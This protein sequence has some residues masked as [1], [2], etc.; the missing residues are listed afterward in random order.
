MATEKQGK[1]SKTRGFLR[2]LPA[3]VAL[4]IV[5]LLASFVWGKLSE[6]VWAYFTDEEGMR[7]DVQEDKD[8]SVLWENPRPNV[9]TAPEDKENTAPD[10]SL[11]KAGNKLEAAFSPN[12]TMMVLVR[13]GAGETGDDLFLSSW[14]GRLWSPPQPLTSLNSAQNERGAAF[15]RDGNFLYFSSDRE[16]GHG[17]YDIYVA[18]RDATGW[19]NVK[20]LEDTVNSASNELGPAPSADGKKLFFSSDRNGDSEDIFAAAI[21]AQPAVPEK[22]PAPDTEP[23]AKA[24]GE[25]AETAPQAPALPSFSMAEA[26]Q[27]LNSEDDDV[28]AALTSRGDHVF[29]ASD[30]DSNEKSGFSVYISRIVK[31]KELPPEKVDLYITEGNTTDPAV[32]MDG[33]DLLFSA[34]SSK[35]STD[36][37]TAGESSGNYRLYRSTTR[38]VFGYTDYT[39]WNK[40]KALLGNIIWWILLAIAALIALIYLLERWRDITDLYH[41]CLAGS[42]VIHLLA[43]LLLAYWMISKEL[44]EGGELQ[45]PEIA[46]SIDALVEEELAL[47]STPEEA[48]ISE[49]PVALVTDKL[50]SDFKIPRFEPQVK[51][52]TTP[53]V[54]RTSKVSLVTDVRPSKANTETSDQP[55]TQPTK[56]T[57]LLSKLPDTVLPELEVPELDERDPGETQ[58]ATEPANPQADIFRPT[59]AIPQ[60]ETEKT[61]E[62]AEVANTAVVNAAETNE[63]NPTDAAAE[64]RDTG[65]ETIVAHT[66]LEALGQPPTLEGSGSVASMNLNLPGTDPKSDPLLPGKLE[67]PKKTVNP[68]AFTKLM[69]KQRGRPS[70]ETIEQ[71]G[72]SDETERAIGAALNWLSRNQEADGRW[73]IK[74]HG[75]NGNYESAGVGLALLCYYGWGL[76]H[77]KPGKHQNNINKALTWLIAQQQ[78]N[79]FLSSN[80]AGN[81]KMYA[82][83]IASIALCEAYGLSKDPKLKEP[84][85]KAI[86]LIITSQSPAKGGWRYEP[87]P[88]DADT[89]VT[90]WQY[91][92]LHS[93]RM[94][95]LEVPEVVFEN[96][97]RWFDQAGGGKF[98]GLY[99]YTGPNSNPAMVA[100]GM[101]CRQ[102]DLVPPDDPRMLESADLLRTRPMR[103]NNPEYYYVYYATLALYQHQGPIWAQWNEALKET[104][105]RIQVKNGADAG[106]W[107]KGGN[108]AAQGGRVVSTTLATLSLEVYY[109]LLPMYG[110]RSD[111]LPAAKPK[112]G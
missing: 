51:T 82:H 30:R 95:G 103:I 4:V 81:G 29:L 106:S 90:G 13:K 24:P 71:L 26:V 16:G 20:L 78:D 108:H 110:F 57:P 69:R 63:I 80:A 7:V 19:G 9:F 100:T 40:L 47:E 61:K 77:N 12:G 53:I 45:S 65:G 3:L 85:E 21:I 88:G 5:A 35:L 58:K 86:N 2:F 11:N 107:D 48:Q 94:A 27:D 96:A 104:L 83:G 39:L 43:L 32:R 44:N 55:T 93:A 6:N 84:A 38:E 73:D 18:S 46:I 10:T 41:K 97:R 112:G 99:G 79:G 37:A 75:G 56:V 66:G 68:E 109:R 14:D 23:S 34:D 105:P 17:G 89:S 50:V 91:M 42:A 87:R 28:Q 72:G 49:T 8:R 76:S 70:L 25:T 64:T 33:F 22:E 74:K 52:Q 31:G 111:Q 62:Q 102:L 67:T 54:A 36:V 1:K 101:F 98:G 60:V 92:A 15:S 59:E